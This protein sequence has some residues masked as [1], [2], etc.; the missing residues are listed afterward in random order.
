MK[1]EKDLEAQKAA[2]PEFI[3]QCRE[4]RIRLRAWV[5]WSP[6]FSGYAVCYGGNLS[7]AEA[8][9][10]ARIPLKVSKAFPG[11]KF[12]FQHPIHESAEETFP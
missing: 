12:T 11:S 8:A 1:Q 2:L 6:A 10:N 4:R 5:G 7:E 9:E 3:R